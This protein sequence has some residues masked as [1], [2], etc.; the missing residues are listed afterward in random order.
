MGLTGFGE[1]D[2]ITIMKDRLIVCYASL[3]QLDVLSDRY[4]GLISAYRKAKL[5][6]LQNE[7]ERNRGLLAEFC[8]L[9]AIRRADDSVPFPLQIETEA[10]GKPYLSDSPWHIS[11]SHS[12]DYAA[13]AVCSRPVGVD[14]EKKRP[15]TDRLARKIC[16]DQEWE[17]I[18]KRSPTE[19]TF[20]DLFS[21]KESLV[22]CSGKGL[23]ALAAADTRNNPRIRQY[24]FDDYVVSAASEVDCTWEVFSCERD[25]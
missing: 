1:H 9:E 17:T 14:V 10:L 24:R 18:W 11:L 6:K 12:N 22:K 13:A 23:M 19:E 25:S 15:I 21:A 2:K 4:G 5:A 7:Q 8:L 16:T 3:L 20:R